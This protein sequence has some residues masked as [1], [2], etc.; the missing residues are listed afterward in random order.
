MTS[1]D[2]DFAAFV[3]AAE[4]RLLRT[5]SLLTGDQRS[6]EELLVTALA[7]VHRTWARTRTDGARLAAARRALLRSFLSRRRRLLRGEQVVESPAAGTT[8]EHAAADDALRRALR[9]LS[10]R[11]R[12]VLVLRFGDQ[13]SETGTAELLGCPAATVA[14][15]TRRGLAA[16]DGLLG[17]DDG[18]AEPP[19]TEPRG[20]DPDALYRR[21]A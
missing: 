4:P 19:T 1:G 15:E 12:A 11:T 9:K 10:P 17:A 6:A 21:P 8:T 3:V 5:A 2:D 18:D 13:L 7:R 20:S 16:L 14:A